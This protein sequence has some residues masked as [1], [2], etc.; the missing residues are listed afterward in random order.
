[1][2]LNKTQLQVHAMEIVKAGLA[3]GTIKLQ[4]SNSGTYNAE[5]IKADVEYLNGLINGITDNLLSK[6]DND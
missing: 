1:M 5:H 4:G 3:S 2:A 6:R